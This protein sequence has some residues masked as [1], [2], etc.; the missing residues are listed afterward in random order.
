MDLFLFERLA[1]AVGL[2]LLIGLQRRWRVSD[3]AGIRTF[4]LI[5][6]L[7]ALI[8][9]IEGEPPKLADGSGARGSGGRCLRP[10]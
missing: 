7:G 3:I 8:A 1:L 2:G 9:I 10:T 5:A 4:P 6:M